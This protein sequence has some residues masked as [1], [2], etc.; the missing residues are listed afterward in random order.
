VVMLPLYLSEL[1]QRRITS[2]SVSAKWPMVGLRPQKMQESRQRDSHDPVHEGGHG[3][4]PRKD[5][6]C[7]AKPPAFQVGVE[8]ATED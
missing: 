4:D 2:R 8:P 3:R 6:N 1:Y 5:E 7:S